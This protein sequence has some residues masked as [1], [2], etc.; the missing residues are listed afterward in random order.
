MSVAEARKLIERMEDAR[1]V[2][3]TERRGMVEKSHFRAET[4]MGV[5]EAYDTLETWG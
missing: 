1:S 2:W 4:R 3:H 5:G